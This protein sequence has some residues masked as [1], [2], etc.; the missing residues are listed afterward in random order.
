[1]H[2][3]RGMDCIGGV[4]TL[5]DYTVPGS[6]ALAG[7]YLILSSR[8]DYTNRVFSSLFLPLASVRR[9]CTWDTHS[10]RISFDLV[11]CLVGLFR[12]L[13]VSFCFSLL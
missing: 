6:S 2:G 3:V 9:D 8:E 10:I 1:M 7:V 5:G 13:P 12:E 4:Q 11:F